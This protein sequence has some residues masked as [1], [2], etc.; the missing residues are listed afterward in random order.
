MA[1]KENGTET[2]PIIHF[3]LN[4]WLPANKP[5]RFVKFDSQ[6]PQIV[7]ANDPTLHEQ[8]QEELRVKQKGFDYAPIGNVEGMPRSVNIKSVFIFVLRSDHYISFHMLIHFSV[9]PI[10]I[11]LSFASVLSLF[12][13]LKLLN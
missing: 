7:K 9:S 1:V 12:K 13:T 11:S 5:M 8:R 3:P 6:L 10:I 4:R 2:A